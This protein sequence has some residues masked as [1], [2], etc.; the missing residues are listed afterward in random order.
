MRPDF[1]I[2]ST[3]MRP[4]LPYQATLLWLTVIGLGAG[5]IASAQAR[6]AAAPYLGMTQDEIIACAGE[7]H[8]RLRSGAN[9]ETLTYRYSG[10][11]PV[12]AEPDK[13]EKKKKKKKS[14]RALRG[15]P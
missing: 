10:A 15:T 14:P 8:S 11:G 12:P 9:A 7:P 2:M 6:D 13:T 3:A 1:R 4:H 5:F